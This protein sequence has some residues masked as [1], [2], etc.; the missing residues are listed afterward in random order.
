MPVGQRRIPTPGRTFAHAPHHAFRASCRRLLAGDHAIPSLGQSLRTRLRVPHVLVDGSAGAMEARHCLPT[1]GGTG[2]LGLWRGAVFV[3]SALS[4][5]LGAA[6]GAILPWK[7]VPGAYCWLALTLAGASMYALAR[8][9]LPPP[10]ALFA[11]A[12]YALN[13]YHLLIIYWRSAYAELL[14]AVFVPLVLLCLLRLREGGVR[15]V[16]WL[17]LTLAG[18][19]MANAPSAMMIHYSAAGLAV[20]IAVRENSLRE[21]ARFLGRVGIAILLGAGLASLYLVPAVYE[22]PWVNIAAVMS[23]GVRPQDN[24]LFTYLPD[25]DHNR[26]NLLVSL[27]A[28]AEVAAL[29]VAAWFARKAFRDENDGMPVRSRRL[30]S[31][32][33]VGNGNG[34]RNASDQQF[35]LAASAEVSVRAASLPLAAVSECAAGFAVGGR[36]CPVNFQRAG[37]G[38]RAL[39]SALR[40]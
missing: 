26:F 20:L 27:L 10:D 2:A 23:V 6:L 17:S 33:G 37:N 13:P 3:L 35:L 18:A 32:G 11:A 28:L 8:R 16:L 29:S 19:W 25:S 22:E 21:A 12:F 40:C 30:D 38:V 14:A 7:I 31:A 5:T 4:W 9:W 36:D 39:S 34:F 15:P 24:F 1:L